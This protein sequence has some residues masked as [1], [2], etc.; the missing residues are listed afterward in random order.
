[1]ARTT[2]TAGP[3][4]RAPLPPNPKAPS[5]NVPVHTIRHRALKASI[6]R[7]DTD[8]GPMYKTTVVRSYKEGN[9]WRDTHSFV[10]DELP[11]VAKLFFDAHSWIAEQLAEE[12]MNGIDNE[13]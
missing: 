6:W 4:A 10:F 11:A 5:D 12:R 2:S 8:K 3:G 7:N 9:E 1:M 13:G